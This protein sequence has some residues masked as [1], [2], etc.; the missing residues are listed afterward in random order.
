MVAKAKNVYYRFGVNA[1]FD[2]LFDEIWRPTQKTLL[3]P[4]EILHEMRL[5]KSEKELAILRHA[6]AISAKAERVTSTVDGELWSS[7]LVFV[8]L[9]LVGSLEWWLRKRWQLK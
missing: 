9:L 6:A 4:E 7:P 5:F 1:H 2:E 3:N 8:V